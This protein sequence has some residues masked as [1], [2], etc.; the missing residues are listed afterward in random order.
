[1]K[2]KE[3]YDSPAFAKMRLLNNSAAAIGHAA[4]EFRAILNLIAAEHP[5]LNVMDKFH[6]VTMQN[7]LVRAHASELWRRVREFDA[8]FSPKLGAP[9]FEEIMKER[10][11]RNPLDGKERSV[12]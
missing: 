2:D 12:S 5:E 6:I 1:M 7:E 10:S 3:W 4:Q 9:S 11:E 8:W